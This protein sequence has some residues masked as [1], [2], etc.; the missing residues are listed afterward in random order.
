M[1]DLECHTEELG[2]NH[3]GAHL[4]NIHLLIAQY[5]PNNAKL[6]YVSKHG[7]D[8]IGGMFQGGDSRSQV[9]NGLE[10]MRA[11]KKQLLPEDRL[12]QRVSLQKEDFGSFPTKGESEL[13]LIELA[14]F[15]SLSFLI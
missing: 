4:F 3:I 14:L 2:L 11:C 10:E 5:V 6:F 13:S 7:S 12:G 9:E 8:K 1:E 15:L